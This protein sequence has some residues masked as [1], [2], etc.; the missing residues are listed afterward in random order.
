MSWVAEDG[1]IE[2]HN[3]YR[4]YTHF[5]RHTTTLASIT[6]YDFRRVTV[7]HDNGS[8]AVRAGIVSPNYFDT[9]EVPNRQ[10]AQLHR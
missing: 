5:S 1:F 9:L 3:G 2:T 7:M 6:V 8:Y 4:V 10:G